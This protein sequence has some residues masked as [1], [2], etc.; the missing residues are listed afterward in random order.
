MMW[1]WRCWGEQSKRDSVTMSIERKRNA[2]STAKLKSESALYGKRTKL[3]CVFHAERFLFFI[4]LFLATLVVRTMRKVMLAF[5]VSTI[6]RLKNRSDRKFRKDAQEFA[7]KVR[8]IT[9]YARVYGQPY[10]LSVE[11]A[12]L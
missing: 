4:A 2:N 7:V 8:K 10:T 11:L 6:S 1:R 5:I 12:L 9:V 3:I